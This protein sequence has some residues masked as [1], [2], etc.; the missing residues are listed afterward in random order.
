M[1]SIAGLLIYLIRKSVARRIW[2]HKVPQALFYESPF[3][4]L[5]IWNRRK[6]RDR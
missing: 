2:N 5:K 4:K 6:S 3:S 1:Q